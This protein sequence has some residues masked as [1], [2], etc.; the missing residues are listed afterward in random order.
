[1]FKQVGVSWQC[2][3]FRKFAGLGRLNDIGIWVDLGQLMSMEH[4]WA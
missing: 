3:E 2:G 1:M 4:C